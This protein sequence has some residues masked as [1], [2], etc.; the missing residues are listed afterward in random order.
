MANFLITITIHS[1]WIGGLAL[2]LA[3]VSYGYD[4]ARREGRSLRTVLGQPAY[5]TVLWLGIT[6]VGLGLM[7][8]SATLLEGAAWL[9][10]SLFSLFRLLGNARSWRHGTEPA[11]DG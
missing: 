3:A 4:Q 11:E 8:T 5:A 6:L 10:L 1:L 9:V 7:L 2:M